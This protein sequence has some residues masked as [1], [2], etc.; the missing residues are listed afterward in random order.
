MARVTIIDVAKRAGVSVASASRALNGL[1]ASAETVQKV[2]AAAAEL[3][4]AADAT[5][6]SLKLGRTQQLAYAVADI[7][8][9]VYV[10]MMGA[11]ERVVAA[12]DYRLVISSTGDA[13]ATVELVRSLGRG[14][15]DGMV[16]SPLR[17]TDELVAAIADSPVPVVVLGRMPD[18]AAADTVRA[19]SARGME[20]VV[21]HLVREGRR[22]LAFINGPVDTTPGRFRRD[23]FRK[24]V[25]SDPSVSSVEVVVDDFTIAEGYRAAIRL[26]EG[27]AG[28]LDALVAANDLI[29]IG[30]LHAADDLGLRVPE[31]IAVTGVDDTELAQ[32]S[33]PGLT[34]VDLGAAERG[35]V[36]A[37]LLLARLAEPDRPA[38]TVTVAPALRVRGSSIA[39][40]VPHPATSAAPEE[41]SA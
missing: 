26:L 33:R 19:D 15:V 2:R 30:A 27:S 1:V 39:R 36:A 41:A 24:A 9:P 28:D 10:E 34:S 40:A 5:A 16:L 25:S 21:D 18:D 35:R 4:Y 3:G 23:G 12:S 31:D 22:R 7:G 6:R 37:E 11:I 29:G 38:H 20:L 8:N 14:F 32:V 17:V 13:D